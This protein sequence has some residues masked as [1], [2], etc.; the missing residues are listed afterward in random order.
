MSMQGPA[1]PARHSVRHSA[2]SLEVARHRAESGRRRSHGAARIAR[3]YCALY[4]SLLLLALLCLGCSVLTLPLSLLPRQTAM[5]VSRRAIMRGFGWFAAWLHLIGAYRLDLSAIDAVRE[6]PGLILAPN[7]PS[8]IDALLILTR[9]PNLACVMKEELMA[10]ALLGPGARL[11][12]YIRNGSP[13][14]M[15]AD[16]IRTLRAGGSLLLFPEGTRSVRAPVNE[17]K[18]SVAVIAHHARASVQTLLIETDSAFLSKGW[19]LWS[20]P[21]LPVLFRVRLGRRFD[22]PEDVE[23]FMLELERYYRS[24][25]ASTPT[26]AWLGR[27]RPH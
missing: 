13:R 6:V 4:S 2:E 15:V 10:N 25:L 20:R 8:L 26:L 21:A 9:H 27:G 16:A 24:E 22:P 19:S 23:A 18:R 14:Q 7:H 5:R 12:C 17:L 1:L 3:E 11:A